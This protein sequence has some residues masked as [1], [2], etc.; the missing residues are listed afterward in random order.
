MDRR[1]TSAEAK[2]A[3]HAR[4]GMDLPPWRGTRTRGREGA[5]CVLARAIALAAERGW[6]AGELSKRAMIRGGAA[7]LNEVARRGRISEDMI[8]AL[9]LALE[10]PRRVLLEAAK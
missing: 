4:G 5:A 3:F 1:R 7:R 8:S 6:D 9:A 2:R 10:V